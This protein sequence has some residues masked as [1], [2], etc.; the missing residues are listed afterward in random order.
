MAI[1]SIEWTAT[2]LPGGAKLPGYTFNPWN[3]CTKVSEGCKFCY[4]LTRDIRF[5]GGIHWGPGAPRQLRGA[6]GWREPLHWNAQ[7][8][9]EGIRRK[10]FCASLAD[11]LDDEVPAEWFLRLLE[12]IRATPFLDWLL[13]TKR[14][15]NWRDRMHMALL[16][17]QEPL[18]VGLAAWIS[19]WIVGEA[20][21]NVWVGTSVENQKWM[22]IRLPLLQAI[23][24]RIRF[25]S[26]EPL[27]GPVRFPRGATVHNHFPAHIG[28][29]GRASGAKLNVHWCI[30][31]GE[32]G[33]ET[34]PADI[35]WIADL[36]G[37]CRQNGV[38]IF[39]KQM[40]KVTTGISEGNTKWKHPKGGDPSEWP[41]GFDVHDFPK[42]AA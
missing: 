6:N 10:V 7:A 23:P 40:G 19:R 21:A 30:I 36:M 17:M 2:L 41:P 14:P 12:L 29:D 35:R 33:P 34:R 18:D 38:A 25:L 27:L 13:L 11:W 39:V 15:Q 3:G 32:S 31:G 5:T 26:C 8:Q 37:S 24:A 22:E 28:E 1:T 4:A 20:P 42:E 16:A 9:R